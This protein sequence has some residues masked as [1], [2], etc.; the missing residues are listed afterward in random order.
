MLNFGITRAMDNIDILFRKR[1]I[2][3]FHTLLQQL[4]LMGQ[5]EA[6]LDG[7]GKRHASDLTDD[8]LNDAINKLLRL[9]DGAN[10]DIRRLR[11][12]I[13]TILQKLGIYQDNNSW[14][15]VN[16]Y[17]LQPRIAGKL[18]YQM[19]EKE[20][21]ELRIKLNSILSKQEKKVSAERNLAKLN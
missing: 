19:S 13:L 1:L 4:H 2:R 20:L 3:L 8:E 11:S 5:K 9:R 7:Y 17:L 12:T 14:S 10:A 21:D 15:R 6:I 16:E 18:L